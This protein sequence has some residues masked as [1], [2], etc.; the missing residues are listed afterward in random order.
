LDE[1]LALPAEV[2]LETALRPD[3][4]AAYRFDASGKVHSIMD[5][6]VGLIDED[7]LDQAADDLGATF[8]QLQE[9]LEGIA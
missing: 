2:P 6:K 3:Q 8:T 5:S 4:V 1:G 7:E 9:R